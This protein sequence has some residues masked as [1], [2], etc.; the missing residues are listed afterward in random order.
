MRFFVGTSGYSYPEWKGTFYP[1]KIKSADMLEYYAA[2][3]PTVEINATFYRMPT[4]AVIEGWAHR[5]P[6]EFRFVLKASRRITHDRRL[7]DIGEPLGYFLNAAMS[8]GDRRG[9]LLFQLPPNLKQDLG[10]LTDFLAQLPPT[11]Q[12]AME[13]RHASWFEDAVLEAL[14][15]K[16]VALC[17]ADTEDGVDA[18][19]VATAP[20]GY[21]RLRDVDYPD[22][23]LSGFAD[24]ARAQGWSEAYVF[25]KHEE[26]GRG[27]QFAQRFIEL[28]GSATP[29]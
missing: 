9:P 29:A 6:A 26:Q 24:R 4:P 18:P 23:A 8:L 12:A 11:V 20:W 19:F 17:I 16:Q 14:R 28:S 3:F 2:R 27:P 21:L 1:E 10:R 7:L 13:F 5:V 22:E 25:F 15:A